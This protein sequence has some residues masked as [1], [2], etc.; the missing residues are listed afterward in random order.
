MENNTTTILKHTLYR[1]LTYFILNVYKD[2]IRKVTCLVYSLS[3]LRR[4][5]V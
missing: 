4:N 2:V 5:A 3:Q 1:H